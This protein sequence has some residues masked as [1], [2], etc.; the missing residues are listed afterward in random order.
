MSRKARVAAAATLLLAIA[1]GAWLWRARSS[2]E[3]WVLEVAIPEIDRLI[4]NNEAVKA[5]ALA[6]QARAILPKDPHLQRLWMEVSGEITITDV[7]GGRRRLLSH[8]SS[9]CER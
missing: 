6:K 9:R 5:A 2:R 7:S 4:D 1:A 8:V 3:R